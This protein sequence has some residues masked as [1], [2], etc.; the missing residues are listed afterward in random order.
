MPSLDL[1]RWIPLDAQGQWS[2]NWTVTP[3]LPPG[4]EL[5]LQILTPDPGA[6]AGLAFSNAVTT[7]SF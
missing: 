7:T 6:P 3:G 1:L 4:F 5:F 2:L